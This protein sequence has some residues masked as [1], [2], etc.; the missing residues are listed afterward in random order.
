MAADHAVL[1][2]TLPQR[3]SP[4]L[5]LV[6]P[7]LGRSARGELT[8]ANVVTAP[9][10]VPHPVAL[11]RFCP[12]ALV[13]AAQAAIDDELGGDRRSLG[14]AVGVGFS[15]AAALAVGLLLFSPLIHA[16]GSGRTLET[17]RTG[18]G[19][20]EE[21]PPSASARTFVWAPAPDV[22]RY[23]LELDRGGTVVFATDTDVPRATV[24]ASWTFGGRTQ[25]LG[26]GAYRWRVWPLVAGRRGTQP[27]VQAPLVIR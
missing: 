27:I 9:D 19:Q 22:A 16:R 4:E 15:V 17:T 25:R 12:D 13:T 14:L 23:R 6:D 24:R 3:V 20:P 8:S 21:V 5:V 2:R 11:T 26:P 7:D 1:D 10:E 18:A